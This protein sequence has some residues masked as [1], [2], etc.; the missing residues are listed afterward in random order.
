MKLGVISS[1][2]R[3]DITIIVTDNKGYPL[4]AIAYTFNLETRKVIE[5]T[6][7]SDPERAVHCSIPED[8]DLGLFLSTDLI[9][10][11]VLE[12][13]ETLCLVELLYEEI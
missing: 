6:R 13:K 1:N 11:G 3:E 7:L 12:L 9:G 8:F 2:K 4:T 10:K 5:I